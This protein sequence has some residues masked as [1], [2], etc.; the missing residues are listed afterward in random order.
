MHHGVGDEVGRYFVRHTQQHT[1]EL[2][3]SRLRLSQCATVP[4]AYASW[5]MGT[6]TTFT[7]SPSALPAAMPPIRVKSPAAYA[8]APSEAIQPAHVDWW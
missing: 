5:P 2:P 3:L 6:R 7:P 8:H 4:A 1:R